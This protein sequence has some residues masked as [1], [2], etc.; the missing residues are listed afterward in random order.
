MAVSSL[1]ALLSLVPVATN[2]VRKLHDMMAFN[3]LTEL[4]YMDFHGTQSFVHDPIS[5]PMCAVVAESPA[6][7]VQS[8][9]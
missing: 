8:L 3:I 7:T 4:K 5:G 1:V 9:A 6:S 2:A